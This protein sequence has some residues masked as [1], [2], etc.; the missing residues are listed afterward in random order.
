MK[1][2]RVDKHDEG[3]KPGEE[4]ESTTDGDDDDD[5][6]DMLTDGEF[7]LCVAAA[8]RRGLQGVDGQ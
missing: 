6:H 2:P 3:E 4:E 8:S 1:S 5:G 7:D